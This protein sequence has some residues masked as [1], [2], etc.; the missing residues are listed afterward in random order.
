VN[1]VTRYT[2]E[3]V[4]D[5]LVQ[6][7]LNG[8]NVKRTAVALGIPRTTLIEWRDGMS[9]T[10]DTEKKRGDARDYGALRGEVQWTA[11]TTALAMVADMPHTPDGLRALAVLA[12]IAAGKHLDY[13]QGRKG[14][15]TNVHVGDTNT[16][17][18]EY[19]DDWR[20]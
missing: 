17:V 15:T 4:R 2:D 3:Q 18:V 11:A 1:P 7:E 10:T 6:L 8:G 19:R 9:A 5:A 14:S 16:L 20:G 12:G 13:T